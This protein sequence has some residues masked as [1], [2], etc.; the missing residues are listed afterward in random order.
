MHEWVPYRHRGCGEENYT[1]GG[2]GFQCCHQLK[3]LRTTFNIQSNRFIYKDMNWSKYF[4]ARN[5]TM[6]CQIKQQGLMVGFGT[7]KRVPELFPFVLFSF[8]TFFL[9]DLLLYFRQKW[10]LSTLTFLSSREKKELLGT[11]GKV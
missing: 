2:I 4:V 11:S 1:E 5:E 6:I 10:N 3:M 9:L 7:T 8:S